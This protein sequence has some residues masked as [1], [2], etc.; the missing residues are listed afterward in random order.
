MGIAKWVLSFRNN[1]F[2]DRSFRDSS[3]GKCLWTCS[4]IPFWRRFKVTIPKVSKEEGVFIVENSFERKSYISVQATFWQQFNQAPPCKKTIEQNI[5]KYC[6]HETSLNRNKENYGRQRTARCEEV[7]N[8]LENN[9]NLTQICIEK[10]GR[11]VEW[12]FAEVVQHTS[13]C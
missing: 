5:T 2:R 6:S 3:G 4:K 8:V 11:H 9:T 10:H 13:V 7:R 1:S 12:K